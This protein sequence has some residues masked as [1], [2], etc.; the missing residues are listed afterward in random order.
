MYEEG[1][2]LEE[3]LLLGFEMLLNIL[4]N[5]SYTSEDIFLDELEKYSNIEYIKE[6]I[7]LYNEIK[8]KTYKTILQSHNLS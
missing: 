8:I 1:F 3:K 6:V 7:Y 5:E 4:E 2:S